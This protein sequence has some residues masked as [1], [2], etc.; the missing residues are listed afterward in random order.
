MS[1][2]P[3]KYR[4]PVTVEYVNPDATGDANGF[5]DETDDSN[6][7]EFT[8][9]WAEIH[10]TGGREVWRAQQIQASATHL[11]RM[12]YSEKLNQ[13]NT[14]MRIDHMGTKLNIAH[15][16]ADVELNRRELEFICEQSK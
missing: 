10:A 16:P 12:P 1:I 14:Q 3:R 9:G 15:G 13:A 2:N 6:W 8:T 7:I 5:V 4:N 11:L